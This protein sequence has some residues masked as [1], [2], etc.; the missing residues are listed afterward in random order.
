MLTEGWVAERFGLSK[1]TII[2]GSLCF[3]ALI[4]LG[5]VAASLLWPRPPAERQVEV[6]LPEGFDSPFDDDQG[7]L[8]GDESG[9]P[10]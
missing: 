4:L 7:R 6:E 1:E 9:L 8:G 10:E 3:V 5:S 2:T